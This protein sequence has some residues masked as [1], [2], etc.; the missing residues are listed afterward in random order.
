MMKGLFRLHLLLVLL[1]VATKV[2][3]DDASTAAPAEGGA[4][5]PAGGGKGKGDA[6]LFSYWKEKREQL[7][8]DKVKLIAL[9]FVLPGAA[10]KCAMCDFGDCKAA[11]SEDC[12][13]GNCGTI[14]VF[15]KDGK[16][17]GSQR[18]CVTA[19]CGDPECKK[20]TKD[21]E[22]VACADENWK[23]AIDA[24]KGK[25]AGGKYMVC[26]CNT[27]DC[28]KAT[29]GGNGTKSAAG[30][31]MRN[32]GFSYLPLLAGIGGISLKMLK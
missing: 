12:A 4:P 11:K 23:K 29:G 2:Y 30:P 19:A 32:I 6:T 8:I 10:I 1:A 5:A 7:H 3:G 15:D 31:S 25:A 24:A 28:N 14:K 21:S 20:D 22:D 9:L 13:G 18:G 26:S 17:T 27:A 16:E